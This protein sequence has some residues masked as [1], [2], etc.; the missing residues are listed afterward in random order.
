MFAG[1]YAGYINKRYK[2]NVP[3]NSPLTAT[4]KLIVII[5]EIA[6][7]IIAGAIYYYSWK[8]QTPTKSRQANKYSWIIFGV[9]LLLVGIYSLINPSSV[10][11]LP[12]SEIPSVFYERCGI[13]P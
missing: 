1:G 2:S 9:L 6:T 4:E 7:P 13:T 8:K 10:C 3:N 12:E 5:T 11:D